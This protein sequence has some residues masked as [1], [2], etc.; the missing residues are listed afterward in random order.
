MDLLRP[1]DPVTVIKRHADGHEATRYPGTVVANGIVGDWVVIEA[2][3]TV[4][5]IVSGGLVFEVGDR[6]LEWFSPT[7]WFN[8]FHVYA[9]DGISRGWY[10]NVTRP[11]QFESGGDA[12]LVIWPDL[13][14]DLIAPEES[15]PTIYDADELDASGLAQSDPVLHARILTAMDELRALAEEHTG[16]FGPIEGVLACGASD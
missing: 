12:P 1:G 13:Y 14:L 3:W 6:L 16:P 5:R 8:V 4:G 15:A 7:R 9:P 2:W 11:T 10:A